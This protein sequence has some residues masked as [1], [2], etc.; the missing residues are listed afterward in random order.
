M[1]QPKITARLEVEL[2]QLAEEIRELDQFDQTTTLNI[3]ALS[4]L[5]RYAAWHDLSEFES[6]LRS[7]KFTVNPG[8]IDRIELFSDISGEGEYR[9][10][11]EI[12][13]HLLRNGNETF[14]H[15]HR[16][17]FITKCL[18]GIYRYRYFVEMP[19]TSSK[20]SPEAL[21]ESFEVYS[22]RDGVQTLQYTQAGHLME[23]EYL[24]DGSYRKTDKEQLFTED[25]QPMYVDSTYI[26]TV[27]HISEEPVI[28]FV[29]RRGRWSTETRVLRTQSDPNPTLENE[30]RPRPAMDWERDRLCHDITEALL[31]ESN[32]TRSDSTWSDIE[33]YMT[34]LD[35]LILLPELLPEQEYSLD[36]QHILHQFMTHNEVLSVAI[37]AHRPALLCVPLVDEGQPSLEVILDEEPM[38]VSYVGP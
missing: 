27:Q 32:G 15:T 19:A 31:R 3:H 33:R 34:P 35:Q 16:Q 20:A 11:V 22:R 10:G 1:F 21:S 18:Q 13:I 28:T 25:N 38:M 26:H 37:G 6:W 23:V 12:R 4:C 2:R 7:K 36:E 5:M 17:S 29:A 30:S 8:I 14:K 9:D 24:E